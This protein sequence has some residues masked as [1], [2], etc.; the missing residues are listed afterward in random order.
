MTRLSP[1]SRRRFLAGLALSGAAGLA[2]CA[3]DGGG[4]ATPAPDDVDGYPPK[5]ESTPDERDIDTSSFKTLDVE[6]TKVPAIPLDVALY[7]HQRLEARF[8]DARGQTSYD[9]SHILGA[10]L[11]PAPDGEKEDDPVT[12][13]PKADRVV[14]Y[15]G[16]PHHLS[17]LRAA[18]LIEAGHENVYVIDDGF[19]A[20][21]DAGYP[22]KGSKVTDQP[23]VRVIKGVVDAAHAGATAWAWHDPSGQREA[24]P[25]GDDGTFELHLKF[26]DVSLN[27]NVRVETPEYTVEKTLGELVAETVSAES[28]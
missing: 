8:V 22:M 12:T 19:W 9:Q 21:H 15:C 5:P 17:S 23:K 10:V 16:C 13:W 3:S 24:G 20:W 7:W 11:S 1:T 18:S 28:E 27:D 4:T 25:I 26:S 2:G 6:G 14:C